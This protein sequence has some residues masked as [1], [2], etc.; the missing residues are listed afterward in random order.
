MMSL[1]KENESYLATC[2]MLFEYV[3][4]SPFAEGAE[5]GASVGGTKL[6]AMG[7][8]AGVGGHSTGTAGWARRGSDVLRYPH[9]R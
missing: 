8:G 6:S 7:G 2:E 9:K 3:A 1:P 5:L 4:K